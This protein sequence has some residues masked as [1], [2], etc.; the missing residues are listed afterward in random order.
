MDGFVHLQD[1]DNSDPPCP[2]TVPGCFCSAIRQRQLRSSLSTYCTWIVLFSCKIETT[3]ILL[4]HLLYLDG[5]VWPEVR[6][7]SFSSCPPTVPEWFCLARS[8]RQINSSFSTPTLPEWFCS[9]AR[10]RQLLSS[11][12]TSC[13]CPLLLRVIQFNII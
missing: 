10:Q 12:S 3:L 9:A 4:V 6:D 1:R 8:Q 2:P 5:F 13:T 7:K 11:L